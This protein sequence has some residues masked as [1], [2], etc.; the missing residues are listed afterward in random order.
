MWQVAGAGARPFLA[1]SQSPLLGKKPFITTD[2]GTSKDPALPWC[3]YSTFYVADRSA[4]PIK[5]N[6]FW[7]VSD[8]HCVWP[9][10]IYIYCSVHIAPYERIQSLLDTL[11]FVHV[12]SK[13]PYYIVVKMQGRCAR[14]S[15]YFLKACLKIFLIQR[16]WRLA[17]WWIRNSSFQWNG[18][19]SKRL[20]FA[21]AKLQFLH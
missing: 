10:E 4:L 1:P 9:R 16:L 6:P 2:T 14:K 12:T 13:S 11:T 20:G 18:E 15:V 5:P 19:I 17:L 21:N 3:V 8:V 7:Y